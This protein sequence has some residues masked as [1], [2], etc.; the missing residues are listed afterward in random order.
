MPS[1]ACSPRQPGVEP[2]ASITLTSVVTLVT[3]QATLEFVMLVES[4]PEATTALE[5]L[6][7][8]RDIFNFSFVRADQRRSQISTEVCG[9]KGEYHCCSF[10][11]L[12]AD[13]QTPK[14]VAQNT[15][16]PAVQGSE[17]A[18]P[19]HSRTDCQGGKAGC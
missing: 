11:C 1:R 5:T 7:R 2:T 13:K 8:P 14:A 4:L 19:G 18:P 15:Y 10:S 16:G 6:A 12:H 17:A 9:Q 3:E